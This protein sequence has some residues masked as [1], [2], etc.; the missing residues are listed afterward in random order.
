MSLEERIKS[1]QQAMK[2]IK[3]A[4]IICKDCIYRY[5]DTV[6]PGNISHCEMYKDEWK[7]NDIIFH[8]EYCR[9]YKK[10]N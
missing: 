6:I 8:K 1:E 2:P 9:F 4:D 5:D 10:S 3:N 7:P